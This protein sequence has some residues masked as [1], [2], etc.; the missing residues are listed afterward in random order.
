MAR[1]SRTKPVWGLD[2]AASAI[3]GVRMCMEAGRVRILAADILPLEGE[4]SPADIPGRDRRIWQAL[5]RFQAKHRLGSERVAVALP[6]RL[7]FVRPFTFFMVGGRTEEELAQYEMEQHI[8][9]GLDAVLWDY[10]RFEPKGVSDDE[11]Q[12]LLFAIKKESLSNY[13]LSLSAAAIEP[14]L[15]QAAPLALY[16]F[17]QHEINPTEPTLAVDVGAAVTSLLALHRRRYWVRTVSLGGD[18]MTAAVQKAFAPQEIGRDEAEAIKLHL[19][20]LSRRAEVIERLMPEARRFVAELGNAIN[21]LAEEHDLKFERLLLMGG[22]GGMYGLPRLLSDELHIRVVTPAGLG[23]IE[24]GG[25][26]DPAYVNA[27]LPSLATA[28]GLGLQALGKKASRVNIFG[29]TL[30]RRRSHTLVRRVAA[31]AAGIALA[32]VLAFGGLSSYR[33][34]TMTDGKGQLENTLRSVKDRNSRYR[35]AKTRIEA[36]EDKLQKFHDLAVRR[37]VW[38]RVLDKVS[39]MLPPNDKVTGIR[40][41]DKLW[42]IALRL[43]AGGEGRNGELAAGEMEAGTLAREDK[44]ELTYARNILVFPLEGDEHRMFKKV[45]IVAHR[46]SP[47]LNLTAGGGGDKYFVLKLAFKVEGASSEGAGK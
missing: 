18:T 39:R 22:G 43:N 6:G 24:V 40:P 4:A 19:P 36:A 46:R 35:T 2:V 17:I 32:L 12:G 41:T 10:E 27:N 23:N 7:F 44:S 5:Q 45:D 3:K 38:L 37:E 29:A 26:A 13:L 30:S 16:H 15:V 33:A 34:A 1:V 21:H 31:T 47:A 14:R 9:F 28:I 25:T 8:P 11:R 42:L 20:Q